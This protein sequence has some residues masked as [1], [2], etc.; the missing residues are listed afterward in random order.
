MGEGVVMRERSI[1]QAADIYFYGVQRGKQAGAVLMQARS[2]QFSPE[3]FDEACIS[4][5][6]MIGY[7]DV[8]S[9]GFLG[10]ARMRLDTYHNKLWALRV[11]QYG[12]PDVVDDF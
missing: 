4:T 8:F 9:R 11:A 6:R 7:A 3:D 5:M 10:G 2:G 12:K 1:S